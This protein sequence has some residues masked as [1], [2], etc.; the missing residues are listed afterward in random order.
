MSFVS[1]C[2]AVLKRSIKAPWILVDTIAGIIGIIG[3]FFTW[4]LPQIAPYVQLANW[5]I[6]VSFFTPI[7]VVRLIL[8]PYWLLNDEKQS[9]QEVRNKLISIEDSLPNIIIHSVRDAQLYR[10]SDLSAG[11]KRPIYRVIQVWFRN[12][13]NVPNE[14]SI[15]KS[16]TSVIEFKNIANST[17]ATK[18]FGVWAVENPPDFVGSAKNSSIVDI[19]PGNLPIKLNIVLK[20][21]NEDAA[22]A[23]S[24]ESFTRDPGGR[25]TACKLIP[26]N[27][28]VKVSL[29]GVGVSK[30]FNFHL[31]NPG[32]N[33]PITLE[34]T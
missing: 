6:P 21:L 7:F 4:L 31:N 9:A 30:I 23:I 13:P 11:K 20:Y 18:V 34:S 10:A 17:L 22:Y 33:F 16:I 1:Y 29:N 25:D 32:E 24:L 5:V 12:N 2:V 3:A 15:A 14:Q 8:S 28:E 27:Y 26:G 19:P